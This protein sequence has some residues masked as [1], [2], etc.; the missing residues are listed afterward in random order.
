MLHFFSCWSCSSGG[1]PFLRHDCHRGDDGLVPDEAVGK[2]LQEETQRRGRPGRS[3]RKLQA[4][5]KLETTTSVSHSLAV[6]T[7][8]I[9]NDLR[10]QQCRFIWHCSIKK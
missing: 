8:Q 1:H 10:N 2:M 3:G 5:Q 4:I 7:N 9:T 6:Q